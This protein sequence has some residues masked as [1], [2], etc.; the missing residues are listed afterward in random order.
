NRRVESY[1]AF[2]PPI[3]R[4]DT[5]GITHGAPIPSTVPVSHLVPG[6]SLPSP[7]VGQE[8]GVYTAARTLWHEFGRSSD[9]DACAGGAGVQFH[10]TWTGRVH[11]VDGARRE[12][13]S[14][15]IRNRDQLLWPQPALHAVPLP[16]LAQDS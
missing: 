11:G 13:S 16:G 6:R 4:G 5:P 14:R 10:S 12:D 2:P 9:A 3:R 1:V 7:Q 15:G 8:F